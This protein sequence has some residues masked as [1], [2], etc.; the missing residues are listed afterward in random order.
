MSNTLNNIKE[1]FEKLKG[2]FV[3]IDFKVYRF[4]GIAEDDDDYYYCLYDGRKIQLTTVLTRITALKGYI[5]D[6]DYNEMVRLAKLNHHDQPTLYGT[7]EDVS[8]FNKEHK[9]ELLS[10]WDKDTKFIVE[11]YWELN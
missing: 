9:K 3:I 7:K 5:K 1:E 8:E 2:Q 11:P 10:K 4:I 6:S